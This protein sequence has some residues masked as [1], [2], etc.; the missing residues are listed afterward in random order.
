MHR[1]EARPI[2]SGF[3]DPNY[4]II[5]RLLITPGYESDYRLAIKVQRY[6]YENF[7]ENF[8]IL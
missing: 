4:T 8:Q 2:R 5:N 7:R 1:G 6:N 3:F